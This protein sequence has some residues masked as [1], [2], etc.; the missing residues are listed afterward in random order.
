MLCRGDVYFAVLLEGLGY[1]AACCCGRSEEAMSSASMGVYFL[2]DPEPVAFKRPP[3]SLLR[4]HL[5][6]TTTTTAILSF[7]F[8]A[9]TLS[10]TLNNSVT[11]GWATV[12]PEYLIHPAKLVLE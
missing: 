11:T 6:T 1:I 2:F 4:L 5:P 8:T 12:S 9:S 10:F 7:L 3:S